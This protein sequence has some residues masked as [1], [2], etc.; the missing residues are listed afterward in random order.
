MFD[1]VFEF[2]PL[3]DLGH[4]VG[5]VEFQ[6]FFL[7]THHQFERHRKAGFPAKAAFGFASWG[8]FR[9]GA[10]SYALMSVFGF[11]DTM[12]LPHWRGMVKIYSLY[13]RWRRLAEPSVI[14]LSSAGWLPPDHIRRGIAS[15]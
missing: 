1:P 13:R 9:L 4:A 14:M 3:N 5:S 11:L 12:R 6:P 2:N 10:K 15:L 8:L 7:S